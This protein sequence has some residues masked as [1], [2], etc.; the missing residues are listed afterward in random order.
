ML[1][2]VIRERRIDAGAGKPMAHDAAKEQL[3]DHGLTRLALS[4]GAVP[5]FWIDPAS[6]GH[7]NAEA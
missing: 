6:A 3:V 4:A 5:A 1:S 7:S 2:T